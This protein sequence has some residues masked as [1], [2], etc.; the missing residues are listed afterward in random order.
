MTDYKRGLL[1]REH[2]IGTFEPDARV[3]GDVH[4]D[5]DSQVP[6]AGALQLGGVAAVE[7]ALARG[8]QVAVVQ[9]LQD[10]PQVPAQTV[11]QTLPGDSQGIQQLLQAV[12][13]GGEKRQC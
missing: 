4:Q 10:P 12:V 11:I 8:A 7:E 1:K 2:Q 5:E 9:R 3:I 13:S 6:E